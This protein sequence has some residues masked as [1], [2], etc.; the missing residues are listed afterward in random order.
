MKL[1]EDEFLTVDE[2]A[3]MLRLNPQTVRNFIDRGYLPAFRIGRRVRI[4]RSDLAQ[5]LDQQ[6]TKPLATGPAERREP[7]DP[8]MPD[9]PAAND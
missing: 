9:P 6:R 3:K 4:L 5:F 7:G 8:G 1:S 2:V